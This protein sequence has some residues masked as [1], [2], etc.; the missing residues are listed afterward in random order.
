MPLWLGQ[1]LGAEACCLPL[2]A[3]APGCPHFLQ[4]PTH[5]KGP[6]G[7]VWVLAEE[8]W[9]RDYG[10]AEV[11]KSWCQGPQRGISGPT[12]LLR[13]SPLVVTGQWPKA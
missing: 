6:E 2:P 13:L 5:R 8:Q 4:G 3:Q 12:V 7:Q 9:V 11:P 10:Q 1:A